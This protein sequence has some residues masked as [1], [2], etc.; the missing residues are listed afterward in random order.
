M[1]KPYM[2]HLIAKCFFVFMLSSALF[3][4]SVKLNED[5]A[6]LL[7]EKIYKERKVGS[8]YKEFKYYAK[9]EFKIVPFD[10]I[11][12]SLRSVVGG[13]GRFKSAKH[14]KTKV[15]R[16]NQ[17]GEGLI[18]YVVLTYEA[19]YANM[20]LEESYYFLGSS[21]IPKLVYLTLQF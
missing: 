12:Q 3:S 5:S 11:E 7:M 17:I 8:F 18:S 14:L 9:D 13:A 19:K 6:H 20:S 16:R 1:R 21:E 4:C 2:L 10:E 15:S